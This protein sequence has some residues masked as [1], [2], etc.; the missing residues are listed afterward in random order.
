MACDGTGDEGGGGFADE[1]DGDPEALCLG[2]IEEVSFPFSFFFF[3]SQM[4]SVAK[5]I[6]CYFVLNGEMRLTMPWL[7]ASSCNERSR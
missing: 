2:E 6:W 1:E 4:S 7:Y 3:D 5:G